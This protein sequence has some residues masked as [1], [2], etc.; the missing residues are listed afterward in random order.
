MNSKISKKKTKNIKLG[1]FKST[2]NF[3]TLFTSGSTGMPKGVIHGTGGYLLYS[4]YTCIK[5]FGL[6]NNSI[7]LTGSDAGWING[8]T[9]CIIWTSINR[10]LHSNY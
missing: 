10:L 6:N 8:H 4:K 5:K 7:I 2:R 9:L 3:F 1:S